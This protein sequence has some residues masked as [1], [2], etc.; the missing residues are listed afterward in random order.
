MIRPFGLIAF[1]SSSVAVI[2]SGAVRLTAIAE[3]E[4]VVLHVRQL[5]VAG[6]AGVVHDDVDAAVR[7]LHVVGDPRRRVLGGDVEGQRGRRRCP[8]SPRCSSS[9]ACGTSMPRTVA[10]SRCSTRAICS[11]MPRLAPVTS[12]TLPVSGW[13]QSTV[14]AGVG[15]A[16]GADADDLAGDV[17]R[18]GREQEAQRRGDGVLG[19]RGDVDE[20]DGAAAA[21]LLAQRAGEALEGALGDPLAGARRPCSGGVPSTTT[22]AQLVEAAQLR[23][24]EVLELD[25]L[26][27]G[28]RARWRRRPAPCTSRRPRSSSRRARCR[29]RRARVVSALPSRPVAA[30]DDGAAAPAGRPRCSARARPGSAARGSWPAAGRRGCGSGSGSGRSSR[31]DM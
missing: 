18:L 20:L 26:L 28:G 13:A 17:G 1:S 3:R 9:A 16:D 22:R 23:G 31:Q 27:G 21:D 15:R 7:G 8:S 19:V 11:P 14:S 25:E 2:R 30:D 4:D 10:P 6:D 5:L 12:A 24:E 29:G